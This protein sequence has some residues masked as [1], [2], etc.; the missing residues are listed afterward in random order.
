M[1]KYR[2]AFKKLKNYLSSPP[3]LSKLEEGE[4]IY[5]YLSASLEVA[6]SVLVEEG[7]GVHKPIYYTS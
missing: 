5:P 4:T 2:Q 6:S 7:K 1:D 3:L